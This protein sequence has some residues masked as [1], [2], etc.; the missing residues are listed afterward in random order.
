MKNRRFNNL[1]V[2]TSVGTV[3]MVAIMV[4][5]SSALLYVGVPVI[6][7][8]KTNAMIR[9]ATSQLKIA[10]ELTENLIYSHPGSTGT[11]KMST[12]E[13]NIEF[14]SKAEKIMPIYTMDQ[15]FDFEVKG[16]ED[17]DNE[18]DIKVNNGQFDKAIIR[19]DIDGIGGS[20]DC[21]PPSV[22][23]E[24]V[25]DESVY[26]T[27]ANVYGVLEETGSELG[28]VKVGFI[29]W[30][31]GSDDKTTVLCQ[32]NGEDKL[33]FEDEIPFAYQITGLDP[34]TDY[35]V[36]AIAIGCDSVYGLPRD[37]TTK[38]EDYNP[39]QGPRVTTWGYSNRQDNGG[40][41]SAVIYGNLDSFGSSSPATV[42]FKYGTSSSQLNQQTPDQEI[43]DSAGDPPT[44]SATISGLPNCV[45]HYYQAWAETDEGVDF[46]NIRF[47]PDLPG[48]GGGPGG[49]RSRCGRRLRQR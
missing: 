14:D 20:G 37:F 19:W 18:V 26:D 38:R 41:W 48:C 2:S 31:Q 34:E 33:I 13:G 28:G 15:N 6:E 23:T 11:F 25:E 3:L 4:T 27:Y 49:D 40:S 1:G 32:E 7:K 5:T 39:P 17:D 24:S 42:Y 43:S 29:Y 8:N 45:N 21:T 35:N 44:F 46:G 12:N 47:L 10:D 22:E 9:T 16:F 30:E 36:Q